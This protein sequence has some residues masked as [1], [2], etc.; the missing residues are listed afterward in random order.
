[1]L[2]DTVCIVGVGL[3][4]G[5]F[6]MAVRERGLARHVVGAV[7]REETADQALAKGAVDSA[8][9]DLL[10]AARG[11]DLCLWRRRLDRWRACANKSH[12]SYVPTL[13]S[14]M[15]VPPKHGW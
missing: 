12:R 15:L 5:S 6:G 13:L 1:M 4:G 11:S 8:T 14:P 9:T 7:R 3:I 10:A 2:F